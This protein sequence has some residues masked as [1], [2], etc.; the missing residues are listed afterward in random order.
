MLFLYRRSHFHERRHNS[1]EINA[2]RCQ[3]ERCLG[4]SVSQHSRHVIKSCELVS[5]LVNFAELINMPSIIFLSADQFSVIFISH[6]RVVVRLLEAINHRDE[7]ERERRENIINMRSEG[8]KEEVA[9]QFS[10]VFHKWIFVFH[11]QHFLSGEKQENA[12]VFLRL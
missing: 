8:G 6:T 10:F 2:N 12:T 11:H 3:C 5:P 4:P 7:R 1:S 9:L